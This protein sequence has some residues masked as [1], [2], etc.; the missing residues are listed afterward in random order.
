MRE[1]TLL[2][3]YETREYETLEFDLK[4]LD[5]YSL[6]ILKFFFLQLFAL[7]NEKPHES[8]KKDKISTH[9]LFA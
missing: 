5:I 1:A 8:S 4:Y 3:L 6:I 2:S 9:I 7:K